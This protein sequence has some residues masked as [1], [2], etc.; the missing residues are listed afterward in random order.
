[1]TN[2]FKVILQKEEE[3]GFSVYVPALPGCASQGETEQEAI[4]N[5]K[6]AIDLYLES[7]KEDRL[8]IPHD[9]FVLRDVEVTV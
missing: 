2:H 4:S 7:L 1:M 5:I 6:E 8:P 3:G 9:D